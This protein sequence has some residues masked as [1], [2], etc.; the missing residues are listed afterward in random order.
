[1][2]VTP[3]WCRVKRSCFSPAKRN[4]KDTKGTRIISRGCSTDWHPQDGLQP[5]G[6]NAPEV[7]EILEKSGK[8]LAVFQGH[9]HKGAYNNMNAIHYYTLPA[10]VASSGLENNAYAVVQ[11]RGDGSISING[12][13]KLKD[14]E[15]PPSG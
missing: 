6:R 7:R 2:E 1:M 8:V 11:I 13:G 12:F 9:D 5:F 4:L 14:Q 15:L 10:L 3:C